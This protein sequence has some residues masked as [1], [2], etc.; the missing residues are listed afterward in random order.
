MSKTQESFA[1]RI[2]ALPGLSNATVRI[3]TWLAGC[4]S[5]VDGGPIE[6]SMNQISDGLTLPTGAAVQ[7]TGSRPETVKAA[8]TSLEEAGIIRT[9]PGRAIGFGHTSTIIEFLV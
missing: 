2:V 3:G 4:V 7:G 6:L 9:S 5:Y 8:L 1:R